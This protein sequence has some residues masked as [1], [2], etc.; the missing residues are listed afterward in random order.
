MEGQTVP[1]HVYTNWP[2]V[3]LFVNGVS[4]GTRTFRK[5]G[6]TNLEQIERYRLM[7]QDVIYQPGELRAVAYDEKRKSDGRAGCSDGRRACSD[8]AFGRSKRDCR[9]RSGS[10]VRH[11]RHSRQ[12]RH[13]VPSREP[14]AN[15]LGGGSRRAFDHRRGR[16]ARSGILRTSRQKGFGRIFGGMYPFPARPRDFHKY[17]GDRRRAEAMIASDVKRQLTF[18]KMHQLQKYSCN[19]TEC[20]L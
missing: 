11:R 15:L 18:P 20:M 9:R 3:E 16:S 7:W 14:S 5:N 12:Q 8:H 13:R 1:V 2:I 17:H 4:Q 6:E 19:Y 10:G